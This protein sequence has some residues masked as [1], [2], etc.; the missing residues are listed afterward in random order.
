ML[1]ASDF[2]SLAVIEK[3]AREEA[4]KNTE[5]TVVYYA[6]EAESTVRRADKVRLAAMLLAGAGVDFNKPS[7]TDELIRINLGT[8][9]QT[10]KGG[11]DL[12]KAL[13]K[14]RVALECRLELAPD[15]EEFDPKKR[16]VKRTFVP[17][18][19]P[20]VEVSFVTNLPVK[21]A[22]GVK[23]QYKRVRVPARTE[24]RLVCA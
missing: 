4:A 15:I 21:K 5:R 23:C 24:V 16:L 20:T 22:D 12:A 3:E 10:R 19:F 18:D 13:R 17:V 11:K 1:N 6:R 8:F 7:W 9:R 2:K 14:V